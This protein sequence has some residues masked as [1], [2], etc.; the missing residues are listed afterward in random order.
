MEAGGLLSDEGPPVRQEVVHVSDRTRVTRLWFG[1]RAVVSKE[2]QGPDAQQRLRHEETILGRLRGVDGVAQLVDAPRDPGSIMLEDAGGSSL[3]Q[4][5]K[6]LTSDELTELAV[7][8]ARAVSGMHR[9]GVMH[10]DITPA[11]IVLSRD[12]APCLV[13]FALAT[14]LAEIRSEF[15]HH[16]EIVGTL[17]Y[18]APEQTG[19]TGRVVDQRADLYALGATLYELATGEPPFGSGDPLRLTHD[20]LARVPVAPRELNP[21]V[22]AP[23]SAII[24]HLLEKEPDNRYQTAD[25]L[26]YDLE[27][28]RDAQPRPGAAAPPVGEHDLPVRLLPPSRLVGRDS[29]LALLR[30]AFEGALAGECRAVFI[31]GGPGVGK[32]A[33][34]D[35]LR[36]VVT[37]CDGWFVAGKSDMYRR[38]LEFDAINQALRALGRLLLA[39]P[40]DQLA[41][42]RQRILVAVGANAGL[43]TAILP[44]FAALLA[45]PP[46][47]GNPL[48]AQ[49]RAQRAEM[50]VLRAVASRTRPLVVFLDD[51]QWA[52]RTPLGFVDLVLSEE[53]LEGLLLVG[54]YREGEVETSHPLAPMVERW[55]Q[56]PRIH[57]VWLENLPESGSVTM[58]AEMLHIDRP[59]AATLAEL[60][61]PLTRGNPYEIVELLNA[62][63]RDGVLTATADGWQ[64][65]AAA[66]RAHLGH[67]ELAGL[68][69][70]RVAAM[71]AS[72]KTIVE[73]MACLGG[74]AELGML[75]TATAEPLSVVEQ[76]LAPAIE[77]GLLVIEPGLHEAVQFRH[78]RTREAVLGRLQPQPRRTL[79]LTMAR[80]LAEV[81]E[82]FAVAAE[83]YLPVID[84]VDDAA[85]RRG[86]V[87][88]L[89]RAAD[90][91]AL[92]GDYSLLDSLLAAALQ[93]I[94]PG[95]T[96]TLVEVHTGRHAALYSLGRFDEA[97]EQYR[98][99]VELCTNATQRADA[100]VVQLLSL[101]QRGRLMD[102]VSF[103]LESLGELGITVPGADRLATELDNQFDHL[104][105]WL[106]RTDGKDDLARPPITDPTL[107]A[108]TRLMNAILPCLYFVGD[109][110]TNAWLSLEALR[111]WLEHGPGPTL[112]G[113]ASTA[114][115]ATVTQR[116]DYA[117]A[118][119]AVRRILTFG[120]ARG[121]EPDTSHARF[122]F[123][124]LCSWF[125][126][127]EHCVQAGQLARDG[128]IAGGD[129]ANAGYAWQSIAA[130]LLDCAPSLD[131]FVAEVDSG[132]AFARRIG[133]EP[134][135][136][137]F[138][139]Y[140]WL[141]GVLSGENPAE[142]GDTAA[143]ERYASNPQA[144]F[145]AHITRAVDAAISGDPVGLARHTAAA[146]PLLATVLGHYVGA[147]AHVLRALAVAGQARET[148]GEE[149][150]ALLSELDE[151]TR[152]LA[153]RAADTPTN[154]LHL[155]R[156]VE[157][158]RAWAVGDFR[159]AVLAFDAARREAAR[160]QR[161][162]HRALI[163]ERAARLYLAHGV[164]HTG[165]ELLAEARQH[166]LAWGATAK[167][168]HLDWAYPVLRPTADTSTDRRST[169][170]T[171]M[172]DMLGIVS[173]SQALSSETDIDGLQ[174]RVA[175]VLGAMTGATGVHLLL[176]SDDQQD[177]LRPAPA[178]DD[179]V[180][181]DGTDPERGLPMSVL[182][183]VQRTR[184]PLVVDDALRDDRFARDPYFTDTTSCS[185][186]AVPIVSRGALQAVLVLEN[187]LMR[188]S[189]TAER[190]D[191]VKLIAGQLAVSV[192]NAHLYAE[193]RQIADDQAALRRVA[194]FVA[195]GVEPS[196]VFAGVTAETRRCLR[197]KTAALWRYEDN[198]EI[199]LLAAAADRELRAKW[200]LGT[201]TPVEGDNLASAV[202]STGQPARMDDYQNASGPIAARVR[203][204]GVRAA[205]GVPV[206]VDGRVWGLMAIGSVTPGPVP[207]DTEARMNDFAE[208]VATAIANAATR[209]ELQGS[210]DSLGVLATQQTA[211]RR[212]ATL[213][214]RG[215]NPAEVFSAVAEEMA[216][217]LNAENAEVHRFE[218][219]SAGSVVVACYAES[220]VPH[221]PVGERRTFE[222]ENVS[223]QIWRTGRPARMDSYECAAG[224]IAARMREL[225]IHSRVGVPIVVDQ[226]VWGMAVVGSSRCEPL[227]SDTEQR[228]GD[229]AELVATAIVAAA[230]RD[231]LIKSRGRIVAAADETRRRLERD[232]HDGA[233]QRA[234]SLGLQLRMAQ[235]LVPTELG[236]LTEQ[237]SEIGSAVAGLS[238]ELREISHGLHP[239]ALGKS[240][241]GPAIKTLAHRSTL[242]VTLDIAAPRRL[243]ET[244]EVAAYYVVAEALTN[245]AKHA[246][247]SEVIVRI[248]SDPGILNLLVRDNG[249]GGADSAKGSGLIG[250]KDRVEALGG[251]MHV[252]SQPG[253]GTSLHAT[254]PISTD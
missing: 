188:G 116:G 56:H 203:E 94:D 122:L 231:E 187:R 205:V 196:E 209:H 137:C 73:A 96:A 57:N 87:A 1:N 174:A 101:T 167:V 254:M 78:D 115:F 225:G 107:I 156:L 120:E 109:H 40:E 144:L 193:F 136:E 219:D 114:A 72:S 108:T 16:T 168:D 80:R 91:A 17:A 182:R 234:V 33:L 46:N 252:A 38:D 43:L 24:L 215:V 62:L 44:E 42:F 41:Q 238:E 155:L 117:A 11:N 113:P 37:G 185:V 98:V 239:A 68:L 250:L 9:S 240:G 237:L 52:G 35:E 13:D 177:W 95:E 147:V 159:A 197:M 208:L 224:S 213:V 173:A 34:V 143:V 89:R 152:W 221:I 200:P 105:R 235:D 212:V 8:L 210:R 248:N 102:A 175:Q 251:H 103:G 18:L 164:E 69:A 146:M 242:P 140:R 211:L 129:L 135:I 229:F 127:V 198:G 61:E 204:L 134:T 124:V 51:L 223:G 47:P 97:D 100:T 49:T 220:G 130:G 10:R 181:A 76:M 12:G 176:W 90:Q 241:L 172:I 233:Q 244:V 195:R 123:S 158:E 232:L 21:E 171:G 70:A 246:Q 5:T 191:G 192:D 179:A 26:I 132:L 153:A 6:P 99:I 92:T 93:L 218:A 214:A 169:V 81:P 150:D 45:V 160:R 121:Y 148:D 119:R 83:Q 71:P 227:P 15:T 22:A 60:I 84:A 29:E 151:M 133:A 53:P 128:L 142:A 85:E 112:V 14:S 139:S 64:W 184:E 106:D 202:L 243:P 157:A 199:T 206:I 66:V 154:F 7:R 201:R 222:G 249:I 19:R 20:H 48:T 30:A 125:E 3:G 75:Q 39:E 59:A 25:G 178:A 183:Y 189:F 86:V 111:I 32:T 50:E 207:A 166:Y 110:A 65:D 23:L 31:S 247:A 245:A 77:D 186:L 88:L 74:R 58:V 63:R 141:A 236:E 217:C 228:M 180:A 149:R 165:Y 131:T 253:R 170:T 162:W 54:A 230:T 194:T 138:E 163:A 36:P 4:S 2:P 145:F 226:R 161:P 126:P 28:L 82:L 216:R 55:R 27:R 190:L 67:S 79:Q 118:Y 104:Y